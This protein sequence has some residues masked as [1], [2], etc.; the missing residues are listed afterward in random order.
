[1]IINIVI[2]NIKYVVITTINKYSSIFGIH[3]FPWNTNG[4]V[5]NLAC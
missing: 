5:S 2:V 4:V 3:F 1:M